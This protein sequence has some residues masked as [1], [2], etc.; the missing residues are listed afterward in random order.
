MSGVDCLADVTV[1]V[2]GDARAARIAEVEEQCPVMEGC[3]LAEVAGNDAPDVLR[4]RDAE[5]RG[6]RARAA[7]EFQRQ[8]DLR[9]SH[10][11]VA[12]ISPHYAHS[13]SARARACFAAFASAARLAR[14]GALI[15]ATWFRFAASAPW[16]IAAKAPPFVVSSAWNP[17]ASSF[18]G[19]SFPSV[20]TCC[21]PR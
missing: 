10:H 11:D 9:S 5:L 1:L 14:I 3:L 15:S 21:V 19:F 13:L 20:L 12:I 18:G 17:A 6:A 2:P 7:L 16:S 4:E 8:G